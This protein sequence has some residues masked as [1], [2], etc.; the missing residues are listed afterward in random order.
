MPG[1]PSHTQS[2]GASRRKAGSR[3]PRAASA[4]PRHLDSKTCS[5]AASYR[6][7]ATLLARRALQL[8]EANAAF[9]GFVNGYSGDKG[10]EGDK[11]SELLIDNPGSRCGNV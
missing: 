5:N 1:F 11:G 8:G 4:K 6:L 3:Y 10:T 2:L 7:F 9:G